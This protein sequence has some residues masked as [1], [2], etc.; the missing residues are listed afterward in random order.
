MVGYS[1]YSL[2][3]VKEFCDTIRRSQGRGRRRGSL[4]KSVP[5]ARIT[6]ESVDITK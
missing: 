1:Y 2:L 4:G 5:T 3:P 6:L